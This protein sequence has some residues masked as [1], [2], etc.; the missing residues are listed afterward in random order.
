MDALL[1]VLDRLDLIVTQSQIVGGFGLELLLCLLVVLPK[2]AL[3]PS[4]VY[5]PSMALGW[6]VL[7]LAS[8][9]QMPDLVW[10]C[11]RKGRP[12]VEKRKGTW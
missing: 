8:K 11:R 1:D 4:G 5:Q 7:R 6:L 9:N 3:S 10:I 2:R 12:L